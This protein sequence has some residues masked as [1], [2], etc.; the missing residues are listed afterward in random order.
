M[1]DWLIDWLVI[2]ADLAYEANAWLIDWSS[3]PIWYTKHIHAWLIDWLIFC[4]YLVYTKHMLDWLFCLPDIRI[5]WLVDWLIAYVDWS[6]VRSS[7]QEVT[8]LFILCRKCSTFPLPSF[9][10][11]LPC[12]ARRVLLRPLMCMLYAERDRE[13]E[14]EVLP[15]AVFLLSHAFGASSVRPFVLVFAISVGVGW[16][17]EGSWVC[18]LRRVCQ[19]HPYCSS[20]PGCCWRTC[21]HMH[22]VGYLYVLLLL[23]EQYVI[24]QNSQVVV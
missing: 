7:V 20:C 14:R 19:S 24:H 12:R 2:C 8:C 17:C 16:G 21:H 23:L 11:F 13:R 18:R 10:P 4:T 5:T 15:F 9:L 3:V 6:S 1:L 22:G